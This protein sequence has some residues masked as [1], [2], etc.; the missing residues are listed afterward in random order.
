MP[1]SGWREF[2]YRGLAFDVLEGRYVRIRCRD[3]DKPGQ[4]GYLIVDIMTLKPLD[5]EFRSINGKP[6]QTVAVEEPRDA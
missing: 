1:R 5:P 2:R 6:G 4:R 3:L